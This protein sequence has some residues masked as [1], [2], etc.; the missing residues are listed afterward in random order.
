MGVSN[1]PEAGDLYLEEFVGLSGAVFLLT[2]R[3]CL[4]WRL[5]EGVR[6][7]GRHL[8]LDPAPGP[9][10]SASQSSVPALLIDRGCPGHLFR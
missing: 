5:V 3:C 1:R 4:P 6:A 9:V 8:V 10:C 2:Q 7:P